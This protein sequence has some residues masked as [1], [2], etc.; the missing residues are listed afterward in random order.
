MFRATLTVEAQVAAVEIE[1]F[2]CFVACIQSFF[3]RTIL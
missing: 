1:S 3:G 2:T